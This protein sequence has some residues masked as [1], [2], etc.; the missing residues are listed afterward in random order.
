MPETIRERLKRRV[1]RALTGGLVIMLGLWF[2]I[3]VFANPPGW[4]SGW[5]ERQ[6]FT[7][8]EN[9]I[10][11]PYLAVMLLASLIWLFVITPMRCPRCSKSF[12]YFFSMRASGY[13]PTPPGLPSLDKCPNCGVSLDEPL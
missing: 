9:L 7:P 11:G 6:A 4:S 10:L 8:R 1:N 5:K 2:A 12:G 13:M 3:W